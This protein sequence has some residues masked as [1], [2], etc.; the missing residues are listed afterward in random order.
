LPEKRKI[1]FVSDVHLGAPALTN[2]HEREM[3]FVQWLDEIKDD[4]SE[5]YLL[6]DIFDFWYEYAIRIGSDFAYQ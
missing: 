3:L 6:G 2:N 5:L 1:Y 4:A